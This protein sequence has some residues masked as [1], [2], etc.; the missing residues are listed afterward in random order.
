MQI[1]LVSSTQ[2]GTTFFVVVLF[3]KIWYN[4]DK[5]EERYV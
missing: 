4:R 5:E 3:S 2:M 1:R